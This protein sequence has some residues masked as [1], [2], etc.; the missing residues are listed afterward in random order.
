LLFFLPL[1][2]SL[3]LFSFASLVFRRGQIQVLVQLLS[4]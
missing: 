3:G 4:S 1:T 2:Y